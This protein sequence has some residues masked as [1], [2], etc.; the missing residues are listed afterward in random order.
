MSRDTSKPPDGFRV[1]I[2]GGGVAGLET[3]LALHAL[4]QDRV[5]VELL[6]AESHFW[7]RPLAVAEPFEL[8]EAH[9]FELAEIA[10]ACRAEFSLGE[11]REV[12]T[13]RRLARTVSG[14]ELPYNVLVLTTGAR[15]EPAFD[16]AFTFRG[17]ADSE[18][19]QR[20]LREAEARP[21]RLVFTL[22]GDAVWPLPLYELALMTA[23][24]LGRRG[25]RDTRITVVTPEDR[26]LGLFGVAA[27][28]A[29]ERLLEDR[30]INVLAGRHSFAADE[31]VLRLAPEGEVPFDYLVALP[32][33]RGEAIEGVPQDRNGFIATDPH[34]R[35]EGVD[36]LYAAGD[37]TTFP[38]K[39]GGIAAQQADAVAESVAAEVGALAKPTPFRPVLRGLLLTGGIPTYL[40]AEPAGG[41]GETS[42]VATEPLW[43]P[44]GKIV[45]RYLAP[46]LAER[47]GAT[48]TNF[49]PSS[50]REAI[51]VDIDLKPSRP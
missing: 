39:Q 16:E 45:G 51:K 44:P 49:A 42:T 22:P 50:S 3:M 30:G 47:V 48:P 5:D 10:D 18:A 35:V 38:V 24:H 8:G 17:P 36:H 26:P 23:A 43:W 9:C 2:A 13:E 4:A 20:I 41:S 40:R 32:R 21:V 27:A 12:D 6:A 33:L 31:S 1:L 34:G 29:V 14:L 19:F 37:I 7:Y 25:I 15:P 46:F 11:L 28:E